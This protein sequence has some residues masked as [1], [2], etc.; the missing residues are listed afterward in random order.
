MWRLP[1]H[2]PEI[3]PDGIGTIK[4]YLSIMDFS[5]SLVAEVSQGRSL[6]LSG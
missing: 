2:L 1:S 4:N 5:M 6:H 3:V